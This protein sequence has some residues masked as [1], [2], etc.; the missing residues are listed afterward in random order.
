MTTR[1]TTKTTRKKKNNHLEEFTLSAPSATK[2]HLVGDFTNWQASPL[3]LSKEADGIWK[4]AI[5]LPPGSHQ[6]R[7]L[8]DDQWCDD[9]ACKV[10]VANPSGSENAVRE[11][12]ASP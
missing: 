10:R 11:V 9:P 8:V 5:Q 2:V 1:N 4:A 3:P 6:Y 12:K 7:F